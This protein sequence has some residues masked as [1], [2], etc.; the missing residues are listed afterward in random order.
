MRNKRIIIWSLI[1]IIGFSLCIYLNGARADEVFVNDYSNDFE[2]QMS[3]KY[4]R[5]N[6]VKNFDIEESSIL[7]YQR[8]VQEMENRK[9]IKKLN[10]QIKYTYRPYSLDVKQNRKRLGVEDD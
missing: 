6:S 10:R 4:D 2:E 8:A 3:I 7:K 1:I 9:V 5:P